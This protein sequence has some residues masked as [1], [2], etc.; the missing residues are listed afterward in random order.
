MR[1]GIFIL[2]FPLLLL[3]ANDFERGVGY[4]LYGEKSLAK[5]SWSIFFGKRKDHIAQG[6]LSLADGD[7]L[8]ASYHF[9]SYRKESRDAYYGKYEWMRYLGL[10]LA[11]Y[12]IAYFQRDW[13]V[14]RAKRFYPEAQII[15]FV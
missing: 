3:A 10:S 6:Y 5:K 1:K 11:V 12:D 4:F 14:A 15:T 13:F 7:Y 8:K 9:K 2:L